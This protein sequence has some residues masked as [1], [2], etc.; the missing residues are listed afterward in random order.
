ML[1]LIQADRQKDRQTERLTDR[2]QTLVGITAIFNINGLSLWKTSNKQTEIY[3]HKRMQTI[4]F[5]M[6]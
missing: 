5:F 1:E 4:H 6:C 2:Q 3:L